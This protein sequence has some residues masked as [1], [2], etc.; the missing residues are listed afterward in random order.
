MFGFRTLLSPP[1]NEVRQRL[2]PQSC[3]FSSSKTSKLHLRFIRSNA[4][5]DQSN[6]K[7]AKIHNTAIPTHIWEI[8]NNECKPTTIQKE[9]LFQHFILILEFCCCLFA[10]VVSACIIKEPVSS[11]PARPLFEH[12]CCIVLCS[13]LSVVRCHLWPN[14]YGV[15]LCVVT[16]AEVFR[17]HPFVLIWTF[18]LVCGFLTPA[19]IT[20]RSSCVSCTAIF[21]LWQSTQRT[22][23][24]ALPRYPR[25]GFQP[26]C[27]SELYAKSL[28][29]SQEKVVL[30]MSDDNWSTLQKPARKRKKGKRNSTRQEESDMTMTTRWYGWQTRIAM[31]KH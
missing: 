7:L 29:T 9:F 11:T 5:R 1:V 18:W 26:T 2:F 20:I 8:R 14:N 10:N 6:E 3:Y 19:I 24:P 22:A 4:C 17:S 16:L 23:V 21:V 31:Q 13:L 12:D 15:L 27:G 25:A 28:D 30:Q